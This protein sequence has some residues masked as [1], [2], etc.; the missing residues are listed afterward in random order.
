M[1]SRIL[2]NKHLGSDFFY[3]FKDALKLFDLGIFQVG[4]LVSLCDG[5]L[6]TSEGENHVKVSVEMPFSLSDQNVMIANQINR[7]ND[8]NAK[9]GQNEVENDSEQPPQIS[10]QP[11]ETMHNSS[12]DVSNLARNKMSVSPVS[13]YESTDQPVS[14]FPKLP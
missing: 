9:F 4:Y 3:Q 1:L 2:A 13:G 6:V 12:S 8:I 5:Q 11:A 14:S 7:I 10:V